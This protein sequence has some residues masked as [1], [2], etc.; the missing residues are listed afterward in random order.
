MALKWFITILSVLVLAYLAVILF[1]FFMQES[2]L[3]FPV[4]PNPNVE[5]AHARFAFEVEREGVVLRGWLI[6]PQEVNGE[7]PLRVYYGGNAEDISAHLPELVSGQESWLL[8][9]YRGYNGSE[10]KPGQAALFTDAIAILEDVMRRYEMDW[11]NVVLI[12]RSLGS[13]VAVHV[14]S[15]KPVRS[16]VLITPYDSIASVG[17]GHYSWLPVR[18]LARH[19]FN[20]LAVAPEIKQ[21]AL[22]LVGGRDAIIPN[23]HSKRLRD[24][25]GGKTIWELIPEAD[26][27]NIAL[28]PG[29]QDALETFLAQP[30]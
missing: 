27:N 11:E 24:A 14:A 23:Q 16:L 12:G 17:Q 25:W 10:G 13:G 22:F 30:L 26:H 8:V 4:P 1:F 3:F 7:H 6:R 18:L 20:S 29:Y 28:W 2:M 19:P 5:K 9:P 15:Q 21:P